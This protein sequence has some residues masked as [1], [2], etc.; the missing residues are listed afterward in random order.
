MVRRN[1]TNKKHMFNV[2]TNV[3]T[4]IEKLLKK[5]T[6][7]FIFKFQSIIVAFFLLIFHHLVLTEKT[8]TGNYFEH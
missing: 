6:E 8:K 3:I 1:S 4:H 7:G 5:L 2:R